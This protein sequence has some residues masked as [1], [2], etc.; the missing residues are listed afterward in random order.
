MCVA[1]YHVVDR[2]CCNLGVKLSEK[3]QPNQ[4][5][6]TDGHAV[7]TAEVKLDCSV[8]GNTLQIAI[9]SKFFSKHV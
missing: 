1:N 8:V 4:V 5:K 3:E 6:L 7:I 2:A 9:M